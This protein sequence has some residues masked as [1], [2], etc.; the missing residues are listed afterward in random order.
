MAAH[1][2]ACV[3][4]VHDALAD[5]RL[6]LRDAGPA[7]HHHPAGLV[8]G[9]EGFTDTSQAKRGLRGARRRAV[10][11]EVR[12]AHARGLHLDHDLAGAGRGV[13]EAAQLDLAVAEEDDAAH[14]FLAFLS[15]VT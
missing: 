9:D 5:R 14:Y 2:A 10:E 3:V 12:A 7:R 15:S 6:A 8:A 1:A 11:L 4:V 13:G